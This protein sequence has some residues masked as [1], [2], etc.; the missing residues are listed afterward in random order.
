MTGTAAGAFAR[1]TVSPHGGIFVVT[2]YQVI[3]GHLPTPL[4]KK[5]A[6][7]SSRDN[8]AGWV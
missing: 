1:G 5:V 4:G 3:K 7:A 2:V 6:A 8:A